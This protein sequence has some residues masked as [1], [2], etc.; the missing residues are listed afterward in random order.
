MSFKHAFRRNSLRPRTWFPSD[1]AWIP[2]EFCPISPWN[3][4]G[5]FSIDRTRCIL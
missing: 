4:G 2:T 1:H 5:T 3:R